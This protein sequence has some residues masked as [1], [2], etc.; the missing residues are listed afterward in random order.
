MNNKYLATL[1]CITVIALAPACSKRQEKAVAKED[2]NTMIELDNSVFET[3]E[4]NDIQKS[5]V[6]F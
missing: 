6:K 1:L 2:L 3:E 4:T 5:I